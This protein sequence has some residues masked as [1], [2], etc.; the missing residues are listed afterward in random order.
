[1]PKGCRRLTCGERCRISALKGSGQPNG[2]TARRPGR[3]ALPGPG[4]GTGGGGMRGS[5]LAAVQAPAEAGQGA[6][7]EGR[8]AGPERAEAY[9]E[10]CREPVPP[11]GAGLP[12]PAANGVPAPEAK[13]TSGLPPHAMR[14]TGRTGRRLLRGGT[15]P[16]GGKAFPV[17]GPHTRWIPEGRAGC[18]VGPGVPVCILEDR[19]GFVLHHEVM[20]EGGGVDRAAPVAGAA[21]A[22][23]PD[24]RAA[25]SGRGFH[26]PDSRVRPDGLPG[27]GALPKKG[28]LGKAG[29][30]RGSGEG[31]SGTRRRPL[32][33]CP[34]RPPHR[35]ASAPAKARNRVRKR[36]IYGPAAL[37]EQRVRAVPS[38]GG[39]ASAAETG[40]GNRGIAGFSGRHEL[41]KR[42]FR[43]VQSGSARLPA[44]NHLDNYRTACDRSGRGISRRGQRAHL[45]TPP[46][47]LWKWPCSCLS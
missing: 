16:H 41:G 23:F 13:R 28:C 6:V 4:D 39:R 27:R 44:A 5:R 15:V 43:Q 18:P 30:E 38:A 22:R 45:M 2:G 47:P 1:M 25:G 24:L 42:S 46:V 31:L 36:R 20:R 14:R 9:P 3:G 12:Q 17:F 34:E 35:P 21:R 7:P 8:R 29:R 26:S 11:A 40:S 37:P 32:R 10:R 33:A 19:H